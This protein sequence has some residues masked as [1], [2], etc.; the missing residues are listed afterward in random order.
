MGKRRGVFRVLV[1]KPEGRR[2]EDPGV[3]KMIILKWIFEKWD[4][5]R[6]GSV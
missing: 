3:H 1:G 5:A 6:T 2:P 4:V